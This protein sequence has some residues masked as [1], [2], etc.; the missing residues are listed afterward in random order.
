M[1]I[2]GKHSYRFGF[3]KS[4]R[5]KAVRLEALAREGGKCQICG[6]E[7]IYNDAHHIWYPKAIYDTTEKH[8]VVLCRPCHNFI[9]TMLPECKTEDESEGVGQW[10]K[11]RNAIIVWRKEKISLFQTGLPYHSPAELRKGYEELKVKYQQALKKLHDSGADES[12]NLTPD[13]EY[14]LLKSILKKW[15]NE[16]NTQP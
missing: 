11:I 8:L 6:E 16:K 5:W 1:S 3:L 10:N 15:W 9:H 7:S 13:Q 2:E 12:D 14:D 4:D